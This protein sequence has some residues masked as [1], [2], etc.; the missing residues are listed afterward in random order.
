LVAVAATLHCPRQAAA[1]WRDALGEGSPHRYF[2]L[3]AA[4]A[5]YVDGF[6]MPIGRLVDGTSIVLET[7]DGH[8]TLDF[9]RIELERHDVLD[10]E[11]AP[12]ESRI[13][14]FAE[15]C[16]PMPSLGGGPVVDRRQRIDLARDGLEEHGLLIAR[17]A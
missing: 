10:A 17:A 15:T 13:A 3:T 12:C 4:H 1:Q 2:R 5:V 14:P 8:D 11:G 9:F 16:V 6:L 7:A